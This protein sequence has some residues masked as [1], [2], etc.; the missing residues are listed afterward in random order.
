MDEPPVFSQPNYTFIVMEEQIVN[1]VGIV[2]ARD[3]D[4]ANKRI[5]SGQG[6]TVAVQTSRR[7]RWL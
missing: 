2:T 6:C 3:P 5:R 4:Q 7:L 1:A